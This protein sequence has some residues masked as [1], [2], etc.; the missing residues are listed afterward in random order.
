VSQ[1]IQNPEPTP[2]VK[3]PELN[4]RDLL[5]DILATAKYLT[6]GYNVF[7]R[8]ASHQTL[9][10]DVLGMLNQTHECARKCYELMFR[11]GWYALET[12]ELQQVQQAQQQFAGYMNQFPY[13]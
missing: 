7:A 4:D 13:Q 5:N 3:G 2:A 9:H 1:R 6:D 10:Q 8:E 12:A 11:K